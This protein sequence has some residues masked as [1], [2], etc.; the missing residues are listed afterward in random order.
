MFPHSQGTFEQQQ[1][2]RP[3]PAFWGH[4]EIIYV[5]WEDVIPGGGFHIPGHSSREEVYRG[6]RGGVDSEVCVDGMG[7]SGQ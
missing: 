7:W 4:Q 2:S 6:D 3:L 1:S 5:L